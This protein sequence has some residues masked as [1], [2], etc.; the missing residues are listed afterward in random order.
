METYEPLPRDQGVDDGLAARVADPLWL[1]CR[2]LQFGEFRGEDAGTVA[3]VEIEAESHPLD[4]W[5]PA[6]ETSWRPY[7]AAAEPLEELVEREPPGPDPRLRLSGGLRWRRLL[8][9]AGLDGLL[10]AFRHRCGFREDGPLAAT[11]L[12]ALLRA[13]LPDAAALAPVAARLADPA[14]SAAE[15]DALGAPPA[16]RTALAGCAADWLS[17]W[18]ERAP[19]EPGAG[20][21]PGTAPPPAW[22]EHRL[23][24]DF[25]VRASTLPQWEL[26][27]AEYPG[28]RLD[29]W[30]VDA[31]PAGQAAPAGTPRSLPTKKAVPGP[32]TFGGMPASR[33]WE[34]EDA[35]FDFGSVDA[36][37]GDLGR[38]LMV[39][40]ATVYGNDWYVAPFRLPVGALT[41]VT[42]F[43]L[44]DVFGGRAELRPAAEGDPG[45]NLFAQTAPGGTS[46]W[47]LF[48]PALP[49]SVEG[50]PVETVLLLRDEMAN[51]AWAV[52][53]TVPDLAGDP[54][55]RRGRWA[56]RPPDAPARGPY[57]RYRVE[58]DVADF[59]FPLAPE[60]LP[61]RENVRLR[62][63]PL[64]RGTG[65]GP[66]AAPLG[67]L[68]R[69][70]MWL[71][72]E[73]VPRSGARVERAV[74]RARW[75]DG[76]AHTWA[77]RRKGPGIGGVSS[78]LRYDSLDEP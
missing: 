53:Q 38:L 43:R 75:H 30:S 2:Q 29:W 3:L 4:T 59:W 55:D 25:T 42:A 7:D 57:P 10:P 47:F 23:E 34:M 68:L 61:D 8:W 58:T 33:F 74:Q 65:G 76:S 40:F 11:G 6:G 1:L 19:D 54:V 66:G 62:L 22:Q 17:W 46:P 41:R 15:A 31:S 26:R 20:P 14:T 78:G 32:A 35:R 73:E 70:G 60:Q 18:R 51:L 37:P 16:G 64:V 36:A 71:H 9:D 45:W 21:E 24:Y 28:G 52:E 48:A 49:Q 72:E 5:R 77:T 67:R 39:A 63:V 44:T 27:G 69:T 12:P 50:P 13:R 56:A